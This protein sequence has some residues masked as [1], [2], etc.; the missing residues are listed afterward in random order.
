MAFYK[1]NI[2]DVFDNVSV[3]KTLLAHLETVKLQC[4]N[5]FILIIIYTLNLKLHKQK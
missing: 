1:K 4:F 2:V 3:K 5:G